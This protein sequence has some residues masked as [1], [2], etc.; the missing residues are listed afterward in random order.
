MQAAIIKKDFQG[1]IANKRMF[2][3]LLIVPLLMTVIIPTIFI[4]TTQFSPIDEVEK[5]A[6]MLDSAGLIDNNFDAEGL[7][8]NVTSMLLNYILP[9]FFLLIPIMASSVMAANSFV[10]E[11][12][13]NTLETLLYS[14]LPLK[15]IFGAKILASFFLSMA[16]SVFSFIIMMII[17]QTELFF[18]TGSFVMLNINWLIVM[19]LVSPSVALLAINL[20]VR[21]SAKSQ[22]SEES[23]Q[24]SVFL[25]LPIILLVAGQF[26]GIML[27]S[28]W[29]FLAIG[30]AVAAV[31]LF[32][33]R[34]HFSKFHYENIL[35]TLRA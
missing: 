7:Q 12:E 2:S 34:G 20:I 3:V 33:F 14:P 35:D 28:A 4:L 26:T 24:R 11:K 27:L 6:K 1:I 25:I 16:V 15:E 30:A 17:I 21:G 18:L 5:M 29:L 23:Q 9:L 31:A 13:K 10:G 22:S 32:M 8:Q 19:F